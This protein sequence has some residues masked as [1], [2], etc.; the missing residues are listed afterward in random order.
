MKI[1]LIDSH[2]HMARTAWMKNRSNQ[3]DAPVRI[4]QQGNMFLRLEEEEEI[5][6]DRVFQSDEDR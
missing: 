6:L 3:L 1:D 4:R 2:E 5:D